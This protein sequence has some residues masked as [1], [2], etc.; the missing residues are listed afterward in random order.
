MKQHVT[1][2][3]PEARDSQSCFV[4]LLRGVVCVLSTR[5]KVIQGFTSICYTSE[6]LFIQIWH[7]PFA[8]GGFRTK[9]DLDRCIGM[10]RHVELTLGLFV[11]LIDGFSI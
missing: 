7:H 5:S 6:S 3:E 10:R 9:E 2:N 11:Q 8:A 4:C 1:R